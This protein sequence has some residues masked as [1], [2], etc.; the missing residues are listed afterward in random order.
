MFFVFCFHKVKHDFT[1]VCKSEKCRDSQNVS[2]DPVLAV[3]V[4]LVGES[5]EPTSECGVVLG[6]SELGPYGGG[7]VVVSLASLMSQRPSVVSCSVSPSL[8]RMAEALLWWAWLPPPIRLPM[9][10]PRSP[11]A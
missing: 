1:V 8:A 5:D 6:E 9:S 10:F 2:H 11:M 3:I 7:P 4:G